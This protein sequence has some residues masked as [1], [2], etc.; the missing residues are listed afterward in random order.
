[1]KTQTCTQSWTS[2]V[3]NTLGLPRL[4][5]EILVRFGPG[6][7]RGL[8]TAVGLQYYRAYKEVASLRTEAP[9][10]TDTSEGTTQHTE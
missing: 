10:N 9:E 7:N 3:H 2:R 5:F 6:D 8:L 1:M 4:F